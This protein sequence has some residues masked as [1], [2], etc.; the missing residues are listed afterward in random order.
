MAVGIGTV[1]IAGLFCPQRCR[2]RIPADES[3]DGRM[4]FSNARPRNDC[5]L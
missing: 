3:H 5:V 4:T 1:D 2:P